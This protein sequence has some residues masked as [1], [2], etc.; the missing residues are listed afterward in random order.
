MATV[1]MP[2][3]LQAQMTRRAISPRLAIRILLNIR[4]SY[5]GPSS[6]LYRSLAPNHKQLL[7]I[8]DG[9]T[10]GDQLL[11]DLTAHVRF[12]LVHQLHGLD[13]A[14]H[15]SHLDRIAWLYKR[16]RTGRWRFVEGS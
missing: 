14:Q 15:L 11:H 8:L 4:K 12:D 9:L 16:R 3:S 2:S 13:N 5:G 6:R 7:P 10:V 1:R